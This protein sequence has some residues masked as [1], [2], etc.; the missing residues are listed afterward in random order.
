MDLRKCV[1]CSRRKGSCTFR[2]IRGFSQGMGSIQVLPGVAFSYKPGHLGSPSKPLGEGPQ[3][4]LGPQ[5]ALELNAPQVE[6]ELDTRWHNAFDNSCIM[7]NLWGFSLRYQSSVSYPT[8]WERFR[9]T[10]SQQNSSSASILTALTFSDICPSQICLLLYVPPHIFLWREHGLLIFK[11]YSKLTSYTY[12]AMEPNS[13][14]LYFIISRRTPW[15][16]G[17]LRNWQLKLW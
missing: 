10:L 14:E 15:I 11:T 16:L 7:M 4:N 17:T 1:P 5:A 3:I 2:L 8:L 13:V 6:M 12:V 9:E